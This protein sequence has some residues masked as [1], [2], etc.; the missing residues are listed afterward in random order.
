MYHGGTETPEAQM[1]LTT[2]LAA[3][4]IALVAI[5]VSV[6][7]WLNY[8]G[9]EQ[10]AIPRMLDRIESQAAL[11]AA[12]LESYVAGVRGDIAGFRAGSALNALMRAHQAGGHDPVDG[13]T[14]STWRERV[15]N[16]LAAELDAKPSYA[17][18]RFIG[19]DDNGRE[20]VRVDRSGPNGAIRKVPAE[21][22]EPMGDRSYFKETIKL[23]PGE[24]FVSWLRLDRAGT[25]TVNLPRPTL[26]VAT[27]LF[28]PDGKP[29]GI[30]IIDVDMRPALDRISASARPGE[31]VY[32]V[33][34]RGDYLLHPDHAREFGSE[35]GMPIESWQSDFPILAPSLG[36]VHSVAH[37]VPDR[38]GRPSGLALAPAILAGNEWVAVI[39][40]A[41]NAVV[42][43]SAAAIQHTSVLAGLVAVLCAAALA[44]WIA[45]SLSRPIVELTAAV[46]G[47]GRDG[48]ASIPVDASGE[49]G[50]LA[51]QKSVV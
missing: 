27:P 40:A 8:R 3:A 9:V 47:A 39:K 6:V 23:R 18:M 30:F 14:E 49:T 20:I 21:W 44:V 26:R 16:R 34:E 33:N 45:R 36:A 28:T 5:T 50:V 43:A 24:V 31:S 1:T 42:T 41:P 29:S 46:E 12:D 22:L 38:A 17:M 32:L 25:E 10:V 2:K 11:V 19:V 4:M 37:V 15:A 35:L 13:A 7:G 48:S 51:D